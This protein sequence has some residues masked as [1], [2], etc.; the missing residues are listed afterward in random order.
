MNRYPFA[1]LAL[2]SLVLA[3]TPSVEGADGQKPESGKGSGKPPAA[4]GHGHRRGGQR[5]I[6]S[7]AD[8]A[9][10]TL[11]KPDLSTLPLELEHG[12]ITLPRTG[13]DN[14]HAIVAE[15]DWGKEKEAVIRCWKSSR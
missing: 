15:K 13:M 4:A 2:L 10:I 5:L 8:G 6:L 14:Y 1:I 11:W 9:T 7:N 12:A 3:S